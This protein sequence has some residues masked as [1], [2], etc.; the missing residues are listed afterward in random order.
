MPT[1]FEQHL[2][3]VQ[4]KIHRVNMSDRFERM[5]DGLLY[6]WNRAEQLHSGAKIISAGSGPLQVFFLLAGLSIELLL[7]GIQR[8]FDLPISPHHRLHDLSRDVGITINSDDQIIL[9]A[10][11]E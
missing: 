1:S 8:A 11:S 5:H 3:R 6:Y 10:L 2:A 9:K 4:G 7:K